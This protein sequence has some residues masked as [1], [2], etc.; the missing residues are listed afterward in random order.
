MKPPAPFR[1]AVERDEMRWRIDCLGGAARELAGIRH[2]PA[3]AFYLD[4]GSDTPG[5]PSSADIVRACE[6]LEDVR[7]CLVHLYGQRRRPDKDPELRF[8]PDQPSEIDDDQPF[9]D[10]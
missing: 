10:I 5:L 6:V 2:D 7:T 9:Y 4:A 8:Q 1:D 3:A